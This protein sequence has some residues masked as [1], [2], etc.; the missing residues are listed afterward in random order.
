MIVGN[1]PNG[2]FL[3]PEAK[4]YIWQQGV[5]GRCQKATMLDFLRMHP[6]LKDGVLLS[7]DVV[8][9]VKAEYSDYLVHHPFPPGHRVYKKSTTSKRKA[10]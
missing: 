6:V 2:T 5:T 8:T 3:S 7:D 10:Q 9:K 4:V 1:L